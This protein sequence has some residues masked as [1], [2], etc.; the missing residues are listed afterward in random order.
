MKTR[1]PTVF[2]HLCRQNYMCEQLFECLSI[3]CGTNMLQQLKP[4]RLNIF[5]VVPYYQK[6]QENQLGHLI[7]YRLNWKIPAR[8]I[9]IL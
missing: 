6:L 3:S 5:I 4:S 7:H 9:L 8:K 2:L 1:L